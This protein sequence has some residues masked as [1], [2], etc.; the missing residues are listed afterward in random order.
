MVTTLPISSV[1]DTDLVSSALLK[2][3]KQLIKI[4]NMTIE[5]DLIFASDVSSARLL[6]MFGFKTNQFDLRLL[7]QGTPLKRLGDVA[8]VDHGYH[9]HAVNQNRYQCLLLHYSEPS[10]DFRVFLNRLTR[11][12]FLETRTQ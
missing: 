5:L 3:K 7:V 10:P 8:D 6:K 12:R 11:N 1:K 9:S 2:A 4:S